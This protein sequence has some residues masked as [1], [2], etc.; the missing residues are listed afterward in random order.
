MALNCMLPPSPSPCLAV[1]LETQMQQQQQPAPSQEDGAPPAATTAVHEAQQGRAPVAE[2]TAPAPTLHASSSTARGELE[3]RLLLEKAQLLDTL[4]EQNG[5][6]DGAEL[7][8]LI[9]QMRRENREH[10]LRHLD[11]AADGDD[12]PP[13]DA[14]LPLGDDKFPD[15]ILALICSVLGLRELGRL[16]C[17]ARRFTEPTL[18]EPGG[19]GAGGAKLSPIEEGARLRLV[20]AAVA[21]GGCGGGGGGASGGAAARCGWRMRRT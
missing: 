17:V 6:S 19:G 5:C 12:A 20:A 1:V 8:I 14:P 9:A 2:Q 18:T 15:D 10:R 11:A 7:G 4:V 13:A 3:M 16:A 21:G